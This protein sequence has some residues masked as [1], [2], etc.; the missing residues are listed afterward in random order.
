M[1]KITLVLILMVFTAFVINAQENCNVVCHNGTTITVNDSSL[2]GHLQ[3]GDTFIS[4]CSEFAGEIGSD[5][6]TLSL[7][8][9]DLRKTIPLGLY[10]TIYDIKSAQITHGITSAYF[11]ENI[12]RGKVVLI[13]IK[14]FRPLKLINN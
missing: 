7:P 10:Y 4:V 5:C 2:N 13:V 9:L 11:K 14:G 3:H 8:V 1:K 12:P 6:T